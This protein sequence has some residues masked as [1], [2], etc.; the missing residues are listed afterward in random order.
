MI[1]IKNLKKKFLKTELL[2]GLTVALALVPEAIAFAFVA[3]VEPLVGLYAAF[4]VGLVTA[5]FGGR[6]GMISGATGALAVVMVELVHS[7]GVEYLF[8]AVVLMGLIQILVGTLKL[9]KYARIIPETVMLGFV[10]GLAIVI[11]LSQLES[12]KINGDWLT[13]VKLFNSLSIVGLTMLIM[14]FL[15]KWKKNMPG[16]L[17]AIGFITLVV[18]IFN[19]DVVTV[20]DIAGVKG[21]LPSFHIPNISLSLETLEIILPYAII[22]ASI[23]LIES[24]MTLRLV[25]DITDTRGCSDRECMGQGLANVIT[26]FFGGMGG[27]AMIGQ[28]MINMENGGRKRLSGISAALFLLSF[29]LFASSLIEA[30]PVAVLTGVML[31]V[32][33][34]TFEWLSFKII[35]RIPKSDAFVVVLVTVVTIFTD[36]AIAV[37]LG[38]VAS[39]LV[40]AWKKGNNILIDYSEVKDGVKE[41]YVKGVLFFGSAANFNERFNPSEDPDK[42]V[43]NFIHARIFDY[44]GVEALVLMSEKYSKLGKS[45]SIKN[46]S[47]DSKKM[48]DRSDHLG[49]VK[50]FEE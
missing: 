40:F 47:K 23:G 15:P 17:I 30:I 19:I 38:I 39:S 49:K 27:C 4:I 45:L 18:N 44:S 31:M 5:M 42:V 1:N 50:L 36:L 34:A 48:L 43:V 3:G 46:V 9:G 28:S 24:L 11:L 22:F 14:H 32:V 13:G 35:R 21:G 8:A 6:P 7:H 37:G 10:N 20:G 29:I 33:I 25:D 16:A 26:G 12:F 41:Y 2:A